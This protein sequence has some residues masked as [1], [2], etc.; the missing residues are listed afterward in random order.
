M[1]KSQAPTLSSSLTVLRRKVKDKVPK[2]VEHLAVPCSNSNLRITHR[3]LS[4]TK[5][6]SLTEKLRV[7]SSHKR[8]SSNDIKT[9][10]TAHAMLLAE[11]NSRSNGSSR[12]RDKREKEIEKLKQFKDTLMK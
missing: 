10:K 6:A 8:I 9:Q 3:Q 11:L 1:P 2:V 4:A 7:L 12:E 5:S